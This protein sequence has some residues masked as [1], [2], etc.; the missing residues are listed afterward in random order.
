MYV[1][2]GAQESSIGWNFHPP[3]SVTYLDRLA[4]AGALVRR[5]CVGLN[6]NKEVRD[7]ADHGI[8][9]S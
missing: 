8:A 7:T 9:L 4:G 3:L 1:S 5:T 6:E 2:V